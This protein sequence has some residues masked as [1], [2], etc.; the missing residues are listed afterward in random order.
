MDD[1][2]KK[3][4][5]KEKNQCNQSPELKHSVQ[6]SLKLHIFKQAL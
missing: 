1:I 6:E 5:E 4:L 3:N 2:E